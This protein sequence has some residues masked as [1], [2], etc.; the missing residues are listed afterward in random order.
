MQASKLQLD[1][2]YVEELHFALTDRFGVEAIQT[3]IPLSA[4]D[5]DVT[6]EAGQNPDDELEWYFRLKITLDDKESKFPYE[7]TVQLSGFFNVSKDCEPEM[8]QPLATVNAPSILYGAAREMLATASARS[9]YLSIFLPPI[10]FFGMIKEQPVDQ[11]ALPEAAVEAPA[12]KRKPKKPA[13][14]KK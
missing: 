1:H 12:T 5:I 7:F 8:R 3:E 9:R 13:A 4:E 6:V 10:R 2:Y 11:K 14:R